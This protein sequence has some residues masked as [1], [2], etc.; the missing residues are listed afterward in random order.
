MFASCTDTQ[1]AYNTVDKF[2][3]FRQKQE[4]DSIRKMLSTEFT[5]V[6]PADDFI[7]LL[8]QFD[9]NLGRLTSSSFKSFIINNQNGENIAIFTYEAFYTNGNM[10]DSLAFIKENNKYKLLYY[11]FH[12][13]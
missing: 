4:N 11:K 10:I 12:R 2:Y 13:K 3:Y 6:T 1:K 5:K 7:D 9:K 8:N